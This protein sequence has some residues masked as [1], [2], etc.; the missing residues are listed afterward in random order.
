MVGISG[1]TRVD[2]RGRITIPGEI[3]EML[4]ITPETELAFEVGESEL[5]LSKPLEPEEFITQAHRFMEEL[6]ASKVGKAKPLKIKEI[7]KG[8]V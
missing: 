4:G 2:D 8:K 1:K 5:V 6:K 7:W 3:R